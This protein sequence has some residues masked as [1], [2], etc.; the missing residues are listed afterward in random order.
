MT[1]A[2]VAQIVFCDRPVGGALIA[3]AIA[4]L[5][6]GAAVGALIG[7][8]LGV[9]AAYA[10]QTWS[11]P[12]KK[13][14]LPGPNSAI[15]GL[16]AGGI[17]AHDGLVAVPTVMAAFGVC[18][19]LE[20]ILRKPL[21]RIGLPLLSLPAV[22]TGYLVS[23]GYALLGYEFW[24]GG[25]I[26]I[27][28]P[29][30]VLPLGALAGLTMALRF[31]WATLQAGVL[32]LAAALASGWVMQTGVL[33]P[34]ELWAYTVAPATFGVH[35]VFLSSS[36]L[37]ARSGAAAAAL[38]AAL[39]VLW[40]SSPLASVAPP[41]LL[42][43]ILATWAMLG[44][45][46]HR[47]GGLVLEPA[48]WATVQTLRVARARGK[49]I[50]ALTGAGA[51]TAS[52][53]PDYT[54]STWLDPDVPVGVYTW[55]RYLTSPR[56]RRA[57]WEACA[58]FHAVARR[59]RPN[60]GHHALA[61]LQHDGWVTAIV[62][63]NVDGLHQAAG[64]HVIEL[65]GTIDRIH[66]LGCGASRSWPDEPSWRQGDVY[67]RDC[68][69]LLKPAVTAF[70]EPLPAGVWPGARR[71]VSDCGV[72]LVIGSRMAVWPASEL[73][74]EARRAGAQV[75]FVNIGQPTATVGE[76]DRFLPY[77]AEALLPALARLLDSAPLAEE[78]PAPQ[79]ALSAAGGGRP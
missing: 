74:D 48:V 54:S 22:L 68:G 44:W 3:L 32:T 38:A 51:S 52:G 67:C 57:Y 2:G 4:T 35:A 21:A 70:G 55:K 5:S 42:P 56:C 75:I 33:G 66:C 29:R 11:F 34:V 7:S 12:E 23:A 15:V 71:V 37:G 8:A 31:P 59:A 47:A 17:V 13:A 6:P 79:R 53:I 18:L 40:Q 24:R 14:G 1:L 64:S 20:R 65:H 49:T 50:V 36:R 43:F 25:Y 16:V 58:R 27:A 76:N 73:L 10:L 30:A 72:L 26:L 45:A 77:P 46:R 69:G 28:D 19:L 41:L 39:W 63:Q 62:T 9:T 60:A 61:A 78:P